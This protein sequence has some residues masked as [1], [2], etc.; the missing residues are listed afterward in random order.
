MRQDLS[1]KGS[2][3]NRKLRLLAMMMTIII[4]IAAIPA[5]ALAAPSPAI[6]VTGQN[7]ATS[8]YIGASLQMNS[9]SPSAVTWS[10]QDLNAGSPQASNH[11]ATID[12]ATGVLTATGIGVV[13]VSATSADAT[14]F[15]DITVNLYI[16]PIIPPILIPAPV[17]AL[18]GTLS[19]EGG[20]MVTLGKTKV[21]GLSGTNTFLATPGQAAA[22]TAPMTGTLA[23]LLTDT[24]SYDLNFNP[25]VPIEIGQTVSIVE[26]DYSGIIVGFG[27]L[28]AD[29]ESLIGT[30]PPPVQ[31]SDEIGVPINSIRSIHHDDFVYDPDGESLQISQINSSNT[32][33]F[34][35]NDYSYHGYG[36]INPISSGT[37][38]V[39]FY[40]ADGT[41]DR[42][43][44]EV[45]VVIGLGSPY[46]Y[47]DEMPFTNKPYGVTFYSD[48]DW[49]ENITS[50]ALNGNVLSA[51][52][53]TLS[54][55]LIVLQP[56]NLKDGLNVLH[57]RSAGYATASIRFH[58]HPSEQ[59]FFL[60]PLDVKAL[61]G[62][63]SAT[64]IA[65]E[66][67]Y[68]ESYDEEAT[69][70]FQL[71]NGNTPVSTISYTMDEINYYQSFRAEFNLADAAT[72]PAY[73]IR[74]F[75]I[76]GDN[77]NGEQLGYNLGTTLTQEQF[78]EYYLEL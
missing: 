52:D 12:P 72:N 33:I 61:N 8:V 29:S 25:F 55:D 44:Y 19:L 14:G 49:Q 20:S 17:G 9:D 65:L 26:V 57:V 7:G 42:I 10:V 34:T 48:M 3:G 47:D 22:Q 63:L 43:R 60:S 56:Q 32:S 41:G 31:Y 71:M 70:I 45:N 54:E 15:V 23:S 59:S 21:I 2:T 39:N 64:F 40:L 62:S 75:L 58:I 77:A 37:A 18:T 1:Q 67:Y 36:N 6:A 46:L 53:Y 66:N 28:T 35:V 74:A 13:R 30:N 4:A 27:T 24:Y 69:V 16:H 50:L 68:N 11:Y 76:T 51:N 5:F 38:T 78:D 73:T